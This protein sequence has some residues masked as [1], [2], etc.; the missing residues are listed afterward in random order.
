MDPITAAIVAAL[1]AGALSGL[2]DAAKT[3]IADAYN[4]LK[5][6]GSGS[7]KD[8]S[9]N[10]DR[11]PNQS[12]DGSHHSPVSHYPISMSKRKFLLTTGTVGL[13]GIMF[14][15]I[16]SEKII[17]SRISDIKMIFTHS[18]LPNGIDVKDLGEA[19]NRNSSLNFTIDAGHDYKDAINQFVRGEHNLLWGTAFTY[20]LTSAK[21]PNIQPILTYKNR[22]SEP[23]YYHSHIL[24]KTSSGIKSLRDL[25]EKRFSYV[26]E[27]STSGYLY[28]RYFMQQYG[29]SIRNDVKP[30]KAG[31]HI[32]SLRNLFDGTVDACAVAS[33]Y[34]KSQDGTYISEYYTRLLNE[35][36]LDD[37]NDIVSIIPN[38]YDYPIPMGPIIAHQN[39]S[40]NDMLKLQNVFLLLDDNSRKPFEISGFDLVTDSMYDSVRNIA[41]KVNIDLQKW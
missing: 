16:G 34:Y 35:F 25:R 37:K 14:G 9:V 19:L 32:K 18:D 39:I 23:L 20:V 27:Y 36:Y 30:I 22:T 26:D 28:P 38:T 40:E 7:K 17:H 5:G 29:L 10:K 24:T 3:A 8:E 12:S 1:S 13:A 4:K 21:Y 6:L 2:T 15:A 11:A 33:Q 41:Y 31:L